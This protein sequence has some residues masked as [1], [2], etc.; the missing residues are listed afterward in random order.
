MNLK[1][2]FEALGLPAVLDACADGSIRPPICTL[3]A[4]AQWYGFP[5]ALIPLWSDG[6][7]P[8]YIGYWRHWFVDREPCFVKMYVAAEHMTIEIART[9]AQLMGVLAMMSISVE[10]AV[11]P[12]LEQFAQAVGLDCL[13]ELEA[14]SLKTGDDPQGFANVELFS[15]ETPLESMAEDAG[16]YTGDFPNPSDPG[17]PWWESSC[18]FE[19]IDRDM[20]PPTGGQLPAW[21][22][23][24]REKKPL[25]ESF[26]QAGRLDYA[27]LSL[28]ST[29]WSITDA[30]QA[31]VALQARANDRG[32]DAVVDYWLSVADVSAGGY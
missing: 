2:T 8:T 24:D 14:Q 28:N 22:D 3:D 9:P 13:E 16:P 18:S 1:K 5:P 17:R 11:T 7:R 32:F 12:E 6:S 27:W 26:L 20:P 25:F 10:D 15:K 21:F 30:R 31:L 29:G 4:P 19:I 23:P